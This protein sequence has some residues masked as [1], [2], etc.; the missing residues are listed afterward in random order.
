V[1]RFLNTAAG[2]LD[3]ALLFTS[4]A[5]GFVGAFLPIAKKAT[6]E[7]IEELPLP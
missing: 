7:L 6:K 3:A 4:R 1:L 2:R 5:F